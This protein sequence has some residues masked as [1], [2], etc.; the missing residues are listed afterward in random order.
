[1]P[2]VKLRKLE[3]E[4]PSSSLPTII[5]CNFGALEKSQYPTFSGLKSLILEILSLEKI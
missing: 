3:L 1:M 4:Y 5:L 2:R